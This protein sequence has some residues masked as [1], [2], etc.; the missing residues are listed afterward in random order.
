MLS[1]YF[2]ATLI[3]CTIRPCLQSLP[4]LF[5]FLPIALVLGAVEVAI[6]SLSVSFVIFPLSVIYVSVCV[7]QSTPA[8]GLIISPVALVE[9]AIGP[10][11]NA[12]TL[13]YLCTFQPLA[14]ILYPILEKH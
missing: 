14:L 13:A 2:V 7:D 9:R 12:L 4:V 11:L 10:Y 8:I 3:T 6:D 5:I 1:A